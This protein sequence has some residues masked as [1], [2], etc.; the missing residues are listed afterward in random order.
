MIKTK[1]I[2]ALIAFALIANGCSSLNESR[3]TDSS[4]KE[5]KYISEIAYDYAYNKYGAIDRVVLS[6]PKPI[7]KNNIYYFQTNIPHFKF[8]NQEIENFNKYLK[9][10]CFNM[11]GI[12]ENSWCVDND[13]P[14]FYA[15]IEKEGI[16][17]TEPID[18]N[19]NSWK[20][21][22]REI[23][24]KTSGERIDEEFKQARDEYKNQSI[25]YD[26]VNS[27]G[28]GTM[29]CKKDEF[30]Y[31]A[32]YIGYLESKE[33]GKIKVLIVKKGI[34]LN[35]TISEI[36]IEQKQIWDDIKNWYVCEY[37]FQY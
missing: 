34:K 13:K 37:K 19:S 18:A 22:A 9:K 14:L 35:E 30:D 12:M 15:V 7:L 6:L 24:F 32:F 31:P 10:T 29:I 5:N 11:N 26:K 2:L 25:Q 3:L 4:T 28:L 20:L 16:V 36:K 23:G 27:S 21:A 1:R 17:I 33:N 8:T